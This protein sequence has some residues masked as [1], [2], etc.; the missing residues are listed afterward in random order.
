MQQSVSRSL[1]GVFEARSKQ[2][3]GGRKGLHRNTEE[4]IRKPSAARPG[5]LAANPALKKRMEALLLLVSA[6]TGF[7]IYP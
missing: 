1:L 3:G 5:E 2:Y 7:R 6:I 4:R